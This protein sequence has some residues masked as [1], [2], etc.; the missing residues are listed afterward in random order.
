MLDFH[1]AVFLW[2]IYHLLAHVTCA[3]EQLLDLSGRC[4]ISRC[5]NNVDIRVGELIPVILVENDDTTH[6]LLI[7]L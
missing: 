5:A 4:S 2:R 3:S 1:I 7:E 6:K